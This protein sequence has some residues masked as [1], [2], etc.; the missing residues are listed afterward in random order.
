MDAATRCTRVCPHSCPDLAIASISILK[1]FLNPTS[2]HP[3]QSFRRPPPPVFP[4][5]NHPSLLCFDLRFVHYFGFYVDPNNEDQLELYQPHVVQ[6]YGNKYDLGSIMHYETTVKFQHYFKSF[7]L[8]S[9]SRSIA[10][11]T[12]YVYIPR[13]HYIFMTSSYVTQFHDVIVLF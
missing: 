13:L 12:S 4:T 2:S 1:V 9:R 7:K 8:W 5:P 11:Y 6:L 3:P 10:P